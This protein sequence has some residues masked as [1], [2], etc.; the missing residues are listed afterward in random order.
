MTGDFVKSVSD[1]YIELYEQL[2]GLK[3]K[4]PKASEDTIDRIN[5]NIT[6]ALEKL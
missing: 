2:T 4:K 5:T 6:A 1:R 3:F